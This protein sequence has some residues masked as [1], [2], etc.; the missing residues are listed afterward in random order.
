MTITFYNTSKKRNSTF[1]PSGGTSYTGQLTN[2]SG[3]VNPTIIMDFG[4]TAPTY[5]YAY[6]TEFNRYY[7]INEITSV[8]GGLWRVDMTSDP[9][10]SFK[11]A[12][13]NQYEYV[14]RSSYSYDGNIT[15]LKYPTKA[16]YT[17]AR[18]TM[19]T[20]YSTLTGSYLVGIVSPNGQ[21]G[22]V[23]Y[24]SLSESQFATL[25]NNL[26]GTGDPY[27]S[28]IT[29]VNQRNMA[30]VMSNP[31]QYIVSARYYPFQIPAGTAAAV[32]LGT[33]N[34]GN[35]PP[36]SALT[37]PSSGD[38]DLTSH[39]LASTR[40]AYMSAEPFTQRFIY[41]PPVGLIHIPGSLLVGVSKLYLQL[42][43]DIVSGIGRM[44]IYS[45][46]SYTSMIMATSFV[47]G[48]DVPVAQMISGNPLKVISGAVSLFSSGVSAINGNI[49][50]AVTS[51]LGAIGD[52][53]TANIP[54]VQAFK[55]GSGSLLAPGSI[56]LIEIFYD[57]ADDDPSENGRPLCKSVQLSTIP[58]YI[59][60][61][62]G[63]VN[64]AGA[65]ET[66]RAQIAEYLTGGFYYQ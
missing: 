18:D 36:T 43:M 25:R 65:T 66:E 38:L 17:A 32:K 35:F 28:G 11:T 37:V 24:F 20:A 5:N 57:V 39:P 16:S 9:L 60:C 54:E 26:M 45:D 40:G 50:G 31:M 23:S 61:E 13:G 1:Q 56:Q 12:I 4:N 48:F 27:Y 63:E 51:G 6:I 47:L 49:P 2:E 44:E 33:F 29:D 3:M 14:L 62:H 21:L 55:P 58:G 15:D 19:S 34:A 7:W 8:G 46:N 10:A 41:W 22:A 64:A 59:I 42:N 30:I 52:F 53:L